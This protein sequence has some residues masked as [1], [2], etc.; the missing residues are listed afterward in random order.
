MG[1]IFK[2][3]PTILRDENGCTFAY[4]KAH[5]IKNQIS[6]ALNDVE[7]LVLIEVSVNRD[8]YPNRDLLSSSG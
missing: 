4:G 7:S 2:A 1:G 5:I 6:A 8:T 3:M